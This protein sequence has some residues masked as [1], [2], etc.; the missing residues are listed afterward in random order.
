MCLVDV[1]F[2]WK[3]KNIESFSCDKII[4]EHKNNE[5]MNKTV[6]ESD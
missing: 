6:N 5:L 1:Y 3:I 2:F 4:V